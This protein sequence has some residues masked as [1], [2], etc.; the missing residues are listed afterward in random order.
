[1]MEE[2]LFCQ[3]WLADHSITRVFLM[4]C[5]ESSSEHQVNTLSVVSNTHSRFN[6]TINRKILSIQEELFSQ[7][8]LML[9]LL[10]TPSLLLF[11]IASLSLLNAN[12]ETASRRTS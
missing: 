3:L 10:P 12:V 11:S 4:L 1:M 6:S 9:E 8:F 5:K 2:E 7:F